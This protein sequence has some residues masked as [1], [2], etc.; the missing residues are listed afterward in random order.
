MKK[1]FFLKGILVLFAAVPMLVGCKD[2]VITEQH[3]LKLSDVSCTFQKDGGEGQA[4]TVHSNPEWSIVEPIAAWLHVDAKTENSFTLVADKNTDLERAAVVTVKAG[5]ISRSIDIRQLGEDNEFA[6]YRLMSTW[7]SGVVVSPNG[8]FVGGVS[9]DI[10]ADDSFIYYTHAVDLENDKEYVNGPFPQTLYYM[11]E[12][13]CISDEGTIY[14]AISNG[15]SAE[16]KVNGDS[17]KTLVPE[18]AGS[19]VKVG[20]VSSDGRVFVGYSSG[21]PGKGGYVPV[22]V[23]D[24]VYNIMDVTEKNYREEDWWQGVLARG[25]SADGKVMYGTSWEKMM[26]TDQGLMY[27]DEEGVHWGGEDVREIAETVTLKDGLDKPYTYNLYNGLISNASSRTQMSP[28]GEWIACIYR[29]ETLGDDD[30]SIN[31][32][33]VP[34]FYNTKTKKSYIFDEYPSC[35]GMGATDDGIGFIASTLLNNGEQFGVSNGMVVDIENGT[36]IGSHAEWVKSEYGIVIPESSYILYVP[37]GG[38][39]VLG[40]I[41]I[42]DAATSDRAAGWYIVAAEE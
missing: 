5:D 40:G 20:G 9:V 16:V 15:G 32:E 26:I 31:Y 29:T 13:T 21:G 8:K 41:R 25:I 2:E 17:M 1:T 37:A 36:L 11:E 7:K 33:L 27:W 39:V 30:Q 28:S 35:V 42:A 12:A 24:G 18:G 38:K 6:K 22:K 19:E 3:F 4:I 23:E 10:A 34:A 14:V